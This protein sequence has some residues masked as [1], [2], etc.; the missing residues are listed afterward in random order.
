MLS[1]Q[2]QHWFTKITAN[3]PFFFAIL[4]DQHNYASVNGRYCEISGLTP[5][6]L[7]GMSDPQVLGQQFYNHLKPFY[8]RAF[9]GE[10][11][12]AEVTQ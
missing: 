12:E 7:V 2:L 10:S 6:K 3:S 5:E 9:K 8:D 4:D 1:Q 11:I